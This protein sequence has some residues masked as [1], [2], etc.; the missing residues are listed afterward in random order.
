MS[1]LLLELFSEEIPALMQKNAAEAYKTIF[2]TILQEGEI[3]ADVQVFIGPRRIAIYIT[4]LPKFIPPKEIIIRGPKV[5]ATQQAIEGFCRTNNIEQN[6]LS[7]LLVQGQLYYIIVK[8]TAETDI[9]ILLQE[10]IP[11][12]ISKYIWS[13][14]MYWGN[15][16]ISWI[17]P[18]RNILCIFDGEILAI[19]YGHLTA[20][21]ITFGHRFLSPEP[22]V[23]D[24]FSEYQNKLRESN[25]IIDQQERKEI[26]KNQLSEITKPLNLVIKDDEKLL[27][28]VTGLVE[29]P[30]VMVGKIPEIFLT[31]PSEVLV[32]S[33]RTHQKYFS[34][35]DQAGNFAPYFLFVS[36]M[37]HD[38]N[39]TVSGN[40]K[41]L[42]ARLSDAL[43]FYQQDLSNSLESRLLKLEQ[44][45]FHAKIGSIRQKTERIANICNYIIDFLDK[46]EI[47]DGFL[48]E[49]KPSTAAYI[50]VR[51]ERRRVSTTK[52]P[53]R[54]TYPGSLMSGSQDLQVAAR[55]CK[56]DLTTEMVGEFP[57]LQGIMGYY[58][59]KS[60]GLNDQIALAIRDHYKPQ[61]PSDSLPMGDTAILAIAD[62]LDSLVGL[63]LIGE[64]PSGSRDPYSLRRQALG[65]IRTILANKLTINI[66][67]L[68]AY[69]IQLY[70]E[71]NITCI[72][73]NNSQ[74]SLREA[75]LVAT[76][77]P[78]KMT[79]N[80]LL[81]QL[82]P[83]HNDANL[84]WVNTN[85]VSDN[86]SSQI[87]LE[88]LEERAKYYFKNHYDLSL[89][90]AV[91]DF[92]IEG[93]L[94][95]SEIKLSA[96]QKF[97]AGS[98]GENL[99]T[100]YKRANN[101]L[102]GNNIAGDVNQEAFISQYEQQLFLS[103]ENVSKQ[104]D[105]SIAEK[106]FTK[107]LRGLLE[108][109]KPINDFFDNLMVKNEDRIIANNRLL[110]LKMVRQLFNKLAKFSAL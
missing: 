9:R 69:V 13:K 99:L 94:M 10:I 18:L 105:I 1:E 32:S 14:S 26:I 47:V 41:V 34:T 40:E 35:F 76:K 25:V 57:E 108:M 19:K 95:I 73:T 110:L 67:Q 37:R 83:P 5:S 93:D 62:K 79:R 89:I 91:L 8:S 30:V 44:I 59:A 15:Y 101:I 11:K 106:D 3:V 72:A 77:Q 38:Q 53:T 103:L 58:Y 7:T 12:A 45:T 43:Y 24:S 51:E 87:V 85:Q 21:N 78:K 56:S 86:K 107:A 39:I 55:L 31:L 100:I 17:R 20:N 104:I 64:E 70:S 102:E 98:E 27:E 63:I 97:L 75:T 88:F 54:L 65:I 33:M 66:K 68:V 90:N 50:D 48:G 46:S 36:N 81:R 71:E 84:L 23:I 28:E 109:L 80:G 4:K 82:T 96:L 6:K 42:A 74:T 22:I 61:G 2:T 92:D 49:T 60:E 52:S 16:D 29:L